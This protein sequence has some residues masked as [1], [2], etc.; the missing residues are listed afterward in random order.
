MRKIVAGDASRRSR[1]HD[2]KGHRVTL[3]ELRR[4]PRN[5]LL[6]TR[7][8]LLRRLPEIPWFTFEAVERIESLIR[9]DWEMLEIG[10]GTSTVWFGERVR[11]VLSIEHDPSW[12]AFVASRLRKRGLENVRLELR[13]V[14]SYADLS[15]VPDRSLDLVVVDG[16]Q[17]AECVRAALPRLK[18]GGRLYLDNTDKSGGEFREAEALVR[19]AAA[20]TGG[21]LE[22]LAGFT[23]AKFSAHEGIL[24]TLPE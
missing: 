2:E 14:E 13:D 3:R 16:E 4:L 10:S 17:R 23:V 7:R 5:G 11:S 24:L 22:V 1:F 8:L 20:D 21:T 12:H 18:P 6:T 9:S 19:R 15:A